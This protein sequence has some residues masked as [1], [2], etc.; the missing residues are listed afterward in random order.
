MINAFQ[1][2]Q[3]RFNNKWGPLKATYLYSMMVYEKCFSFLKWAAS[4]ALS[5]IMFLIIMVT[6]A[7]LVFQILGILSGWRDNE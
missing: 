2:F 7:I 6:A 4:S 5:W 3:R 1:E